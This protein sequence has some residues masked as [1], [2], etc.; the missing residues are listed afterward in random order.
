VENQFGLG[1]G[2]LLRGG[3]MAGSVTRDGLTVT[4]TVSTS[5]YGETA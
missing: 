3:L 5:A 1:H 4:L 2:L